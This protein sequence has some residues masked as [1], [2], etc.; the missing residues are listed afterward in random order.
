MDLLSRER[1]LT[2]HS[3]KEAEMSRSTSYH[4]AKLRQQEALREA[5]QHRRAAQIRRQKQE[6]RT[7]VRALRVI[8]R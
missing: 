7:L 5:A 4:E 1:M 6:K 2:L 8:G 3:R